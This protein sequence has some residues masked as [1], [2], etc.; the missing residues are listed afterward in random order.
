[1]SH[2]SPEPHS[3][4]GHSR[5]FQ[6]LCNAAST[7]LWLDE[8][9]RAALNVGVGASLR[10]LAAPGTEDKIH[11]LFMQAEARALGN[12]AWEVV[13][14]IDAQPVVFALYASTLVEGVAEGKVAI[15]GS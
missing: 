11:R 3:F 5:E 4:A 1:M 14:E 2:P 8:R 10:A 13:L 12:E 6:L 7:I 15:T 9:A